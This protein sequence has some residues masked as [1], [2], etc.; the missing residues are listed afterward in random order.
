MDPLTADPVVRLGVLVCPLGRNVRHDG[1]NQR[2][3]LLAN[4]GSP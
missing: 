3:A 4:A 2:D 1:G